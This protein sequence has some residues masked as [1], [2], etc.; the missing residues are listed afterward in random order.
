MLYAQDSQGT[1]QLPSEPQAR[2]M[3]NVA[4]IS[5]VSLQCAL[6]KQCQ[7]LEGIL[8]SMYAILEPTGAEANI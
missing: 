4:R 5:Q 6:I 8:E 3:D 1:V 2:T 7:I